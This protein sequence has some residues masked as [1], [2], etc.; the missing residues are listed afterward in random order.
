MQA[1]WI[2]RSEGARLSFPLTQPE[3]GTTEVEVYTTRPDTLMGAS[4]A[5]I[6][7]DHPLAGDHGP[8]ET[9]SSGIRERASTGARV[10]VGA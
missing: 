9:K 7:A 10:C 5:A 2:G 6:S 8:E 3:A 1:N 4:F